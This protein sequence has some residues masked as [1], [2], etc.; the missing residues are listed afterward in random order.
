LEAERV[1]LIRRASALADAAYS[2]VQAFVGMLR[3]RQAEQLPAWLEAVQAS[4]LVE[5]QRFAGGIL[6]DYDAVL[7]GLTW[8]YSNRPVEAQVHKLKLVKRAM[9]GRAKLDLVEQRLLQLV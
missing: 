9:I 2:L 8:N 7:A 5:L 4:H 3:R 1:A 6:K